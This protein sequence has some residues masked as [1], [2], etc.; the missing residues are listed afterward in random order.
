MKRVFG[1][2]EII[3][4]IVYL[5]F[6]LTICILFLNKEAALSAP[7]AIMTL[8]LIVGDA[9]HLIPR[10]MVILTQN[11]PRFRKSLGIGKL[12]TSLTMTVFY[13]LLLRLLEQNL[14]IDLAAWV[15]YVVIGLAIV[16]I[17]LCLFPQ[18]EWTQR[19]PP[20]NWAIYRN[21]PFFVL[22]MIVA[23][24]YF[25]YRNAMPEIQWI[26][27]AILLSYLFYLPVV[28]FSNKNPKVGMLMLPKTCMYGWIL[29]MCLKFV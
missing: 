5:L 24:V 6:G 25:V 7:A 3:F 14:R 10:I 1:T 19:F 26:W 2:V 15:E 4:D 13:L 22:G 23:A 11:E 27:L 17:A 21:I 29:M 20:L 9:F 28:L 18:N 8:V 16:R 12:I